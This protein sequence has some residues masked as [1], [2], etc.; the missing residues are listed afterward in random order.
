MTRSHRLLII[1]ISA[2]FLVMAGGNLA[3]WHATE[4]AKIVINQVGYL[5]NS[6]KVAFLVNS[7]NTQRQ[8]ELINTVNRQTVQVITPSQ[9]IRDRD[10]NDRLQTIDFSQIEQTGN[11]F[12]RAGSIESYPFTIASDVYQKPVIKMLRSYYLQRCGVEIG[13][14]VT[15][16]RHAPCHL[17]DG[18]IAHKDAMNSAGK[19]ISATGGWHDAGDYGKYVSTTAI[20]VGRLL[21]LYENEPKAFPDRQLTIPESGNGIPDLLDEMRV[22]LDWMLSMQRSDGAIYRKLSGKKWP[23]IVAPDRDTQPR[24]I[25]GISTPETAKFAA[26]MAIAAR[27][28][29]PLQPQ[30]STLYLKAARRAWDY[31]QTQPTMKVDWVDGDDSGSGKYLTSEID[32][33]PSLKIDTDDRLWAA[34]E[35]FITTKESQFD[36]YF[37]QHLPSDYTLFEWK[38]P[39]A[40]GMVNYLSESATSPASEIKLKIAQQILNRA[41]ALVKKVSTSGYRLANQRFIW[42]S[43][44]MTATE[45]LTL[46]LAYRMTDGTAY[47][48]AAIDQIDYLLGRNPFNQTFVT[49]IGTHPVRHVNHIFARARKISIPGLLVGGANNGAQDGIAPK[50]RG[51]LSYVDDEKSYATNEYAIDY[52]AELIALMSMVDR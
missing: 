26:A 47:R 8:I 48:Q 37:L 46:I 3:R 19:V 41:D 44:K 15:G 50:N 27:V 16:I 4:S 28:Y 20:T 40:L 25:Y 22:G 9:P 32:T 45:G 38:D 6:P 33:E 34:A 12:L 17:R 11:Y 39:S 18:A 5:P 7:G 51:L 43:N 29:A 13:D 2:F 42:G 31:L 1:L 52:N 21:S 10:S 49:G 23:P 24:F 35:L 14:P 36:R 30:Q